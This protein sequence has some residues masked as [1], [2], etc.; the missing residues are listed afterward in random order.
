MRICVHAIV[1][2]IGIDQDMQDPG[3]KSLA[4]ATATP[5]SMSARAGAYP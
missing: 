2:I 1:I 4:I 5:P 3:L